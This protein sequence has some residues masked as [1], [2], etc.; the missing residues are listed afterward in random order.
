MNSID[1][2]GEAAWDAF[3]AVMQGTGIT[4]SPCYNPHGWEY[5]AKALRSM[6]LKKIDGHD[7]NAARVFTALVNEIRAHQP[8]PDSQD[9]LH[10]PVCEDEHDHGE[11]LSDP[12]Y[13]DCGHPPPHRSSHSLHRT[14]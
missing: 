2:N 1:P 11:H 7:E 10:L 5:L 14:T 8:D 4:D 6:A 3:D 12:C 13:I 9:G